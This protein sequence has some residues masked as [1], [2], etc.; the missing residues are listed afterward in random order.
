MLIPSLQFRMM[1][2]NLEK[3]S[4]TDTANT[5]DIGSGSAW[6]GHGYMDK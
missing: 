3:T 4:A 6:F 1:K 2:Y 5:C